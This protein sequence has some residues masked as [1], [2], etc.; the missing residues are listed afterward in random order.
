MLFYLYIA[1]L[2]S[3]IITILDII[4]HYKTITIRVTR[5]RF[6]TGPTIFTEHN[7]DKLIRYVFF[8][9]RTIYLLQDTDKIMHYGVKAL[10]LII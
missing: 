4:N 7:N 5:A 3:L 1:T 8:S 2:I 10:L 6:D 9:F